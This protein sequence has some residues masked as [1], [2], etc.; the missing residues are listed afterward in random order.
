MIGATVAAAL[1]VPYDEVQIPMPEAAK[2]MLG[3]R[4]SGGNTVPLQLL[5]AGN[6]RVTM[7]LVQADA[8][9][10]V[11]AAAAARINRIFFMLFRF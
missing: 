9:P 6:A 10:Y 3:L 7:K 1:G 11:R 4:T 2:K 8:A 5:N